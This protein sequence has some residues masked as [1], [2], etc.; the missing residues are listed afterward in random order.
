MGASKRRQYQR[1]ACARA[2]SAARRG[3]DGIRI[4]R[5]CAAA[6]PFPP[7]RA[8][9]GSPSYLIKRLGRDAV[10]RHRGE[11]LVDDLDGLLLHD[12][13][14]VV[15]KLGQMLEHD[16]VLLKRQPVP[17]GADLSN[18]HPVSLG[19]DTVEPAHQEHAEEH[20]KE[21]VHKPHIDA[22]K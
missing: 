19:L 1:H 4:Y 16:L 11:A 9:P 7:R 17:L 22:T 18:V 20:R 13:L 8:V 12:Q 21:R 10:V 14:L 6:A 15:V 2:G 3:T 5:K